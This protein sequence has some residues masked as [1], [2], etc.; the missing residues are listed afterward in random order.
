MA[1]DNTVSYTLSQKDAWVP[2]NSTGGGEA[3]KSASGKI[4]SEMR[5]E[6][7]VCQV[8][9]VNANRKWQR[10]RQKRQDRA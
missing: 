4:L 10:Q 7:W 8:K 2:W 3:R 1:K 9:E 5:F 6:G